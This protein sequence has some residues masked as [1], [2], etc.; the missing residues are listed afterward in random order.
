M[1]QNSE[2]A[3]YVKTVEGSRAWSINCHL[4]EAL[5]AKLKLYGSGMMVYVKEK[6][7]KA[8]AKVSIALRPCAKTVR[9]QRRYK[10]G[11]IRI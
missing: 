8:G 2:S 5:R 7:Y 10:H 6:S 4:A 3:V 1:F 11:R 9:L